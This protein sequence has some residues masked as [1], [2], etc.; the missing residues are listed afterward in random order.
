MQL[1]QDLNGLKQAWPHREQQVEQL[2]A[3]LLQR[4]APDVLVH[5][6]PCTGKTAIAR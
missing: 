5:G 6:P 4:H 1:M 2:L 3:L